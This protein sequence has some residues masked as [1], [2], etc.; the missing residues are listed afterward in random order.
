MIKFVFL[1]YVAYFRFLLNLECQ[2]IFRMSN[3]LSNVNGHFLGFTRE[4]HRIFFR[5]TVLKQFFADRF[6]KPR[7]ALLWRGGVAI[8]LTIFEHYA[9]RRSPWDCEDLRERPFFFISLF[10]LYFDR[11]SLRSLTLSSLTYFRGSMASENINFVEIPQKIF[12]ISQNIPNQ[13]ISHIVKDRY[14]RYP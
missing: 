9:K 7:L 2:I 5:D 14:I 12:S 11:S 13:E 8:C 4:P 10:L 6:L 1:L 3:N